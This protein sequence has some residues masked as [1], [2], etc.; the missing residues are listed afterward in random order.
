MITPK[1]IKQL[2]KHKD[3]LTDIINDFSVIKS[4]TDYKEALQYVMDKY[5]CDVKKA[6]EIVKFTREHDSLC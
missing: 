4:K 1:Y 5:H 2:V 6:A 3:E